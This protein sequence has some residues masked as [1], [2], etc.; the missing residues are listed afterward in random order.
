MKNYVF[1]TS[2]VALLTLSISGCATRKEIVRFKEDVSYIRSQTELLRQEN[3]EIRRMCEKLNTSISNLE[4][5][6]RRTKADLLAEIDHVKARS[7]AIDSKLED[8]TYRM[9]H[10]IQKAENYTAPSD[11]QQDSAGISA[12]QNRQPHDTNKDVDLNPLSIYNTAYMDLSR[13]N[14][15]L[16]IQGFQQFLDTFPQSEMADNAL[17]WIGEVYYSKNDFNKAIAEFKKVVETYSRGDKVPAA[18]LKIGYCYL[19]LGD[20]VNSRKYLNSVIEKF[21]STE[22]A[23]LARGRLEEM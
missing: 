21:P 7:Q 19:N 17:Y 22:E 12:K 1:N 5:E 9:S 14:L 16:A 15:Q 10:F 6:T 23:R 11:V 3:A 13:G 4:N 18:L 2:I 8:N 20:R